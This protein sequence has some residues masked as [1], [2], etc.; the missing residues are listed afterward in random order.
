MNREFNIKIYNDS[1]IKIA[2]SSSFYPSDDVSESDLIF[3]KKNY[4][5][6]T[7]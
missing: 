6:F 7:K 3:I 5:F 1:W 4:K 2:D